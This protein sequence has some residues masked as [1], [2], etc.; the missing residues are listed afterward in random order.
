[1]LTQLLLFNQKAIRKLTK[2]DKIRIVVHNTMQNAKF[3]YQE[4]IN[5]KTNEHAK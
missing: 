5:K 4:F 1:M 3:K 2:V